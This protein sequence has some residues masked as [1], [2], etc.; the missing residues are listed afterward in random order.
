MRRTTKRRRSTSM[1][2]TMLAATRAHRR[3]SR[4]R[5]SRFTAS[6]RRRR[7]QRRQSRRHQSAFVSANRC[8]ST[9][10]LQ[11]QRSAASR[12]PFCAAR[13]LQAWAAAAA[14]A[15]ATAR[16]RFS[17]FW[18]RVDSSICAM[19]E[20]ARD[21]SRSSSRPPNLAVCRTRRLLPRFSNL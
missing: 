14:A 11:R 17:D 10:P 15:A 3:A 18:R 1:S 6:A 13:R 4:E 16:H 7:Q 9:T 21:D 20:R 2:C 8:P 5:E 12:L 19:R